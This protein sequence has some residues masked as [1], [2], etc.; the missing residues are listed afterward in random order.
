[1]LN[2]TA[3]RRSVLKAK[4]GHPLRN[5]L[6]GLALVGGGVWVFR[7]RIPWEKLHPS[8]AA[9]PPEKTAPK[10]KSHHSNNTKKSRVQ[11]AS[12][13]GA[14]GM[15]PEPARLSPPAPKPC[16]PAPTGEGLPEEGVSAS[17]GLDADQIR[18]AM[19]TI[20]GHALPCFADASTGTVLLSITAGCDGRVSDISISDAGDFPTDV[21]GCVVQTLRNASFPAHDMPDG[22]SFL[23]PVT[24]TAPE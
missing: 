9:P 2:T 13:K 14:E 18:K 21:T 10:A 20:V 16:L 4:R 24:Y 6:I 3:E 8:A 17:H 15:N 22:Y 1:M 7:D 23:Y 12:L 5:L 11:G 19:D